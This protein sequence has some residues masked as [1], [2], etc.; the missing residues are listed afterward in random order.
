MDELE[1][2]WKERTRGLC[3]CDGRGIEY[4]HWILSLEQLPTSL[5]SSSSS[6]LPA[7]PSKY[8][9]FTIFVTQ[10]FACGAVDFVSQKDTK[11]FFGIIASLRNAPPMRTY[12]G[13]T[14]VPSL[15][16]FFDLTAPSS[17]G[18]TECG[19]RQHHY[20]CLTIYLLYSLGSEWAKHI[21]NSGGYYQ[22]V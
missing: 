20:I 19:S 3:Q 8:L 9:R 10:N 1:E 15:W 12:V 22:L 21:G 17:Q 4:T 11:I 14:P 13:R 6:S 5:F 7:R 16:S 2:V 18:S